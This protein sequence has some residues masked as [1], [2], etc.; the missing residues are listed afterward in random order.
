MLHGTRA[1]SAHDAWIAAGVAAVILSFV[2][3]LHLSSGEALDLA[4]AAAGGGRPF[5]ASFPLAD[6]LAR[7]ALF[8]PAGELGARPHLLAALAGV[9]ALALR[10]CPAG[11]SGDPPAGR[12]G[13][14]ALLALSRPFLEVATRQPTT[15]V[16][17]ALLVLGLRLTGTV[18]AAGGARGAGLGLAFV[19]G[20]AAGAGWPSRLVLWPV[21][22]LLTLRSL[23]R[24]YRWPVLAPLLFAAGLVP[25]VGAIVAASPP[26]PALGEILARLFLMPPHAPVTAPAFWSAARVIGE[27]VGA[28]ALLVA[29][30]GAWRLVGRAP[31]GWG[32]G[33]ASWMT[34]AGAAVAMGDL[35]LARVTAVA[36]AG[37]PFVAGVA[38]LSS[39]F[40][41]ARHAAAAVIVVVA[42]MP[43][44]WVGMEAALSAPTRR[45]PADVARELETA[46]VAGGPAQA[47][48]PPA[49]GLRWHRYH[50]GAGDGHP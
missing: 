42:V 50:M 20:L 24:G 14:L 8:I 19:G 23:R 31:P 32:L 44:A 46:V 17:V 7:L 35:P 1:A 33:A 40:G 21:G 4:A 3:P 22:V 25:F 9:A 41:R 26:A 49:A 38:S 34:I 29:A 12:F 15:A 2:V 37:A 13:A 6:L 28:L 45:A 30:L 11:D 27:D 39:A 43:A 47:G 18:R 36:A 48:T 5:A 10:A 16:D